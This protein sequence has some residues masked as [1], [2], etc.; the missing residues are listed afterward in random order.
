MTRSNDDGFRA[1]LGKPKSSSKGQ[2]RLISQLLA[3]GLNMRG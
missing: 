3:K 2:P 1:K